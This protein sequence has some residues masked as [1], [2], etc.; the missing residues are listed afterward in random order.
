M[1]KFRAI[2]ESTKANIAVG[3]EELSHPIGSVAVV[4]RKVISLAGSR[5]DGEFGLSTDRALAILF[6]EHGVVF[7]G[8]YSVSHA[9][10]VLD[11]PHA[12]SSLPPCSDL[13][14]SAIITN[15]PVPEDTF[16]S[17]S[18]ELFCRF[19]FGAF[20][21]NA[22]RVSRIALHHEPQLLGARGRAVQPA[23]APLCSLAL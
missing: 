5:V 23:S 1:Q 11:S 2:L 21:A 20:D 7:V 17:E 4:N 19:G 15:V 8:G 12:A 6:F 16:Y 3:A 22:G 14:L 10:V 18:S 13:S 9:L